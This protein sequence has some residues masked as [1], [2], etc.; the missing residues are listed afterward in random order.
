MVYPTPLAP[1]P[2]PL[3][4]TI[5]YC[6]L[7]GIICTFLYLNFHLFIYEIVII[8]LP[9]DI[10]LRQHAQPTFA[11]DLAILVSKE[12]VMDSTPILVST[13]VMENITPIMEEV[14]EG[15]PPQHGG[16]CREA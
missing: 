10:I 12:E 6:A 14:V 3:S 1:L 13:E 11:T 9:H 15:I 4:G 8:T 16:G 5:A 2:P 7:A